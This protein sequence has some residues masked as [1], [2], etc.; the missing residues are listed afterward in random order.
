MSKSSIFAINFSLDCWNIVLIFKFSHFKTAHPSRMGMMKTYWGS[1]DE[2]EKGCPLGL[3]ELA[4]AAPKV[5]T[6][7]PNTLVRFFFA[8]DG[9]QKIRLR[10]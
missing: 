4:S 1:M 10:G 5:E 8:L 7:V 2:I 6:A 9:R 3:L